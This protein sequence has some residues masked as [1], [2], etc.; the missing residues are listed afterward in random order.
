MLRK[1]RSRQE[2]QQ[3][4]ILCNKRVGLEVYE[5]EEDYTLVFTRFNGPYDLNSCWLKIQA[6][7]GFFGDMD[8]D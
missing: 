7:P 5:R 2:V 4:A 1:I 8:G 3:P 6:H